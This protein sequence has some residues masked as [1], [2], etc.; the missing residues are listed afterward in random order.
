M[1]FVAWYIQKM[2]V[3]PVIFLSKATLF[4]MFTFNVK[5]WSKQQRWRLYLEPDYSPC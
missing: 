4:V 3:Q 5:E 2:Q 1:V